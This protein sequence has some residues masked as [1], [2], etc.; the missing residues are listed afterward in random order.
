MLLKDEYMNTKKLFFTIDFEDFK[1]DFLNKRELQVKKNSDALYESYACI[2]S[3]LENHTG[4]KRCT[5]FCTGNVAES[6]PDLIKEISNDG[7]EIACHS[8]EHLDVK[9]QSNYEFEKDLEKAIKSLS[10]ACGSDVRGYRAPMFSLLR[11]DIEKYRILS[12]YFKYDSSLICKTEEL[13]N[14]ISNGQ[15]H[16]LNLFEF[17]IIQND[18]FPINLK[19][20]GGTYLKITSCEKIKQWFNNEIYSDIMPMIYMHPYE[21]LPNKPFWVSFDDLTKLNIFKNIYYQIRQHQ[22]HSFNSSNLQKLSNLLRSFPNQGPLIEN[23][24]IENT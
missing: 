5:F 23:L 3:I 11:D 22:W 9:K 19:M 4:N 1:Y 17:P 21:L 24:K 8:N 12:K 10:D 14:Y 7:H 15:I 2:K 18:D 6:S 16:N 20:I 13:T